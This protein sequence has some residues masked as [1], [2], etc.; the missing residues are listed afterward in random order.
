MLHII[1]YRFLLFAGLFPYLL[2]SA[3]AFHVMGSANYTYFFTGL[4]GISAVLLAVEIFNEHFD[5]ALGTDR[6][7]NLKESKKAP[8]LKPGVV[9]SVIALAIGI[10]LALV[11]GWPIMAF[12]AFG[13]LAVV[14]YVGPPI[15]WSY[16]GL[17][18]TMI[19]LNYGPL[20]TFGSYYIQTQRIDISPLLPSLVVGLLVMAL[21]I[22]N[23]VPDYHGDPLVGKKN[24]VVRVGRFR[25]TILHALL[26]ILSF[27][28]SV[29]GMYF[30]ALTR[31]SVL[32]FLTLPIVCWSIFIS[33][34]NYNNPKRFVPTI[35]WT[36]L[37]Y[38]TVATILIIS[39]LI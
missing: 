34:R 17:G 37:L 29:L 39:Y 32:V 12:I 35:R 16:K 9:A 3:V 26:L 25:A 27:T 33:N 19:F 38:A 20:I 6:V 2:G 21:A 7:F 23:E 28:L 22:A 11:R 4:I 24:I 36:A 1:R 31:L 5:V 13:A 8:S 15:R 30:G 18:E 10:Y 14:F